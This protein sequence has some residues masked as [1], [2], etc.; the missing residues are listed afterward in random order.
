MIHRFTLDNYNI[1][2]DV[3]SGAVHVLDNIAYEII[4]LMDEG[5][6]QKEIGEI[7]FQKYDSELIKETIDEIKV[8]VEDGILFSKDPYKDFYDSN[9]QEGIVKSLCLNIAH[10]CNLRC[11]YCFASQGD[12][13]G[14][15]TLMPFEVAAKAIDFLM[16]KSGNRKNL[17]VDFFGG[18]PLMNFDVVKKTIQ[19]G[20]EKEKEFNKKI[21]FTLTTNAVLLDED[22]KLFINDNIEN[23]VLSIDGRKK[24]NDRVRYRVDKSGIYDEILPAI[25]D[26]ADSRNQNNYYVRGTFTR[27]NLD[28]SE[29]VLHLADQGF[30]QISI[31][32]VVAGE[33]MDYSLRDENLEIV[34]KEYKKL[35]REYVNRHKA[36]KG[37]NFFHF[38]LDLSNGPCIAKRLKGCGAGDEYLAITPEGEIYPCHQFVGSKEFCMGNISEEQLN[39]D[40]RLIFRN[41]NIFTKEKC[42]GCWSKFYCSGGCAANAWQF[43]KDISKPYEI[44]CEL[45]KKRTEC[46]LMIKS[47]LA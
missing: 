31:E 2:I 34:F 15:K 33:D 17:E 39:E 46:A 47:A 32:P 23:I 10:D 11:E 43:N 14:A 5:V 8:L 12:F 13:G 44:G 29:D 22:K 21:H 27:Y 42:K 41:T 28:F 45:Q 4:G 40:I 38:Q 19:Y 35:A 20:R 25:K 9:R 16:K 3:Y 7:L 36:G 37:F 26:L 18:E 1:V 24:V 6:D 30:K